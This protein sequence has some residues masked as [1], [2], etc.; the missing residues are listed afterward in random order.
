MVV[1]LLGIMLTA[2]A[3]GIID[4]K[5]KNR[6]ANLL[7]AAEKYPNKKI[8]IGQDW[9]RYE[10]ALCRRIDETK[11]DVED[12]QQAIA[13]DLKHLAEDLADRQV[14]ILL[15]PAQ[16]IFDIGATCMYL[17]ELDNPLAKLLRTGITCRKRK[18]INNTSNQ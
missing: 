18:R 13:L 1:I 12:F 16:T 6:Y 2:I 3:K 15:T 14:Y 10:K 11:V 7:L 8:L 9:P 4:E 5:C 17:H